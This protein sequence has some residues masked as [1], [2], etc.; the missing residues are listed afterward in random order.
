MSQPIIIA[1]DG[2]S[3]SGKSSLAKQL[4]AEFNFKFVDS[5]AYYRAVT[6]YLV[7]NKIQFMNPEHLSEALQAIQISFQYDILKKQSTTLLNNQSV[8]DEIRD[9][10]VS[11]MVSLV[12]AIA[13]V[14]AFVSDQLRNLKN[15]NGIVMDGR[16]I[17]TVVFPNAQ[18][19]FYITA[20][21]KVRS[22][23]RF[24]E[25][26][27]KGINVTEDQILKN[28]SGR[29]LLDS[30]RVTAPLK[31]AEDAIVIDN[32]LLNLDEQFQIAKGYVQQILYG[33]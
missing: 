25:M 18:L 5:G 11:Q 33:L 27:N 8:D 2:L 17:G 1:I 23:R 3:S 28:L 20:D 24:I 13:E 14:R 22:E 21:E 31:K 30:T 19:K 7:K 26:K 6:L 10:D 16:D 9:F 32:T 15:E 29:D 4:A 12:S